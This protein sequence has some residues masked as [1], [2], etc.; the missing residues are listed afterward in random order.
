MPR[1][2]HYI[3][4]AASKALNV[5]AT[6][7]VLREA[8]QR[9]AK[10]AMVAPAAG[11]NRK[12]VI[13]E[14]D[15][16]WVAQ[17]LTKYLPSRGRPTKDTFNGC[18]RASYGAWRSCARSWGQHRGDAACVRILLTKFVESPHIGHRTGVSSSIL[19]KH[20]LGR[21]AEWELLA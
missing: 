17:A 7:K 1:L 16:A 15:H 14:S 3:E 11:R 4:S 19:V 6:T 12:V 8:R 9:V 18:W 5:R 20:H 13:I 2:T 21:H 10:Q